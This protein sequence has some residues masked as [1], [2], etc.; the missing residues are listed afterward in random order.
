MTL[1]IYV[2][3]SCVLPKYLDTLKFLY[4]SKKTIAR[5]LDRIMD[6]VP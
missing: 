3:A 2:D 5:W 4:K 6:R 1:K